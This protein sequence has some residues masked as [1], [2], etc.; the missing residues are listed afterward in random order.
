MS[1]RHTSRAD[2]DARL[3][4][5]VGWADGSLPIDH[6]L[7]PSGESAV[8]IMATLLGLKEPDT[9]VVNIP[10]E[11]LIDNL[12]WDAIV[13]V[14]AYVSPAGVQGLKVGPLPAAISHTLQ[15]RAV[16][17]ELLIEAATSGSRQLALQALLLDAQVVSL[18][19]ANEILDQSLEANAEW[20][21][22]FHP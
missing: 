19:V 10:N 6:L 21:P 11:G 14:P 12:P 4:Q 1:I 8:Q 16:Q 5:R 15:T 2:W 7:E 3:L 18:Q 17:Q 20:L 22:R 9:Y 13:E